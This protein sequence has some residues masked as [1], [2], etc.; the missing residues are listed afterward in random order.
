MDTWALPPYAE[1]FYFAPSRGSWDD[2]D[3]RVVCVIGTAEQEHRGSLRKDAGMLDPGQV[4]FLHAMNEADLALGHAPDADVEDALEEY[5]AW[6]RQVDGALAAEA[7]VLHGAT[8]RPEV[9]GPARAQRER[10][11]AARRQW[12]RA[13]REVTADGFVDAWDRALAEMPV[14]TEQAL[15]GAY[16]L[17]TTVPEWLEGQ[18]E[19]EADEADGTGEPGGPGGSDGSSGSGGS[20]GKP[21]VQPASAG[22]ARRGAVF[23]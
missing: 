10:V 14:S 22:S 17:S 20:S 5:R 2:G 1:M 21:S 8:E 11:E 6:A 18:D 16:G 9:A 13:A 7:L 12:Q 3:R 15:R 19:G 23:P 4:T